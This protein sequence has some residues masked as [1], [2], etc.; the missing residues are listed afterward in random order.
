MLLSAG[1]VLLATWQGT[2]FDVGYIMEGIAML[3]ISISMLSSGI[4]SK[5]AAYVG[6]ILGLMSLVP[7]TVPVIGM[8]FAI[9]SLIP[10]VLWLIFVARRLFQ[11]S[12]H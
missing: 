7:P 2:A 1:Q 8:F 6:I 9:G 10:L 3:M 5:T 11:L 4:F 12:I